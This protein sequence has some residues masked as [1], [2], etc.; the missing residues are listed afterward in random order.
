MLS[1][2]E[3]QNG[4]DERVSRGGA[5]VRRRQAGTMIPAGDRPRYPRPMIEK[6]SVAVLVVAIVVSAAIGRAQVPPSGSREWF[7]KTEQ[8]LM[9]AIAIGD[10]KLW[11]AVLDDRA[12]ITS[13]EGDVQTK[14]EFLKA[15]RPLPAGLAGGI[16]VKELTVDEFYNV[17]VVRFLADEWETVFAQRL[18]T[19]YRMTDTF[20]RVGDS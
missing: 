17:A 11:D 13:E 12:R 4:V 1:G 9:D 19:K 6:R 16:T 18:T 14:A 10:I 3:C 8:A 20:R 5:H 7:Q 2:Q 15:L